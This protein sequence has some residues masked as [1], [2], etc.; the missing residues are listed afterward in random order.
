M[1]FTDTDGSMIDVYQANTAMT[2]ESEQSYPF[3]PNTLFDRALGPL[4]Y[5]GAFTANLHTD[6]DTTFE[7]T[8]T[9]ASA[10]S[11]G[12][13]VIAARQLLTW[14]DGRNASSFSGLAWNTDTLTFSVGVGLGATSLTGMVPTSGP[15]A[16]TLTRDQPRRQPGDLHADDGQ[17][18]GVRHVRGVRGHL[19]GDVRGRR[20][21]FRTTAVGPPARPTTP[22]PWR[23]GRANPHDLAPARHEP[24]ARLRPRHRGRADPCA[25]GHRGR[26]EAEP[27]VLLPGRVEDPSGHPFSVAGASK[28]PAKF[29]TRGP[30]A[31]APRIRGVRAVSL[32][33]GTATVTWST[34]EPSTSSVRFGTSRTRLDTTVS[35]VGDARARRRAHRARPGPGVL[36]ARRIDRPVDQQVLGATCIRLRT[37]GGGVASQ[38]VAEF[39]T[40]RSTG[41][42][43]V[44]SARFGA[45]TLRG[46]GTGTYVSA[47]IDTA[48]K[49][50]WRQ[51]VVHAIVPSGSRA[52]RLCQR[53]KHACPERHLVGMDAHRRPL[54]LPAATCSIASSSPPPP[55][56]SRP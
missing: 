7:D 2:D 38:T 27:A 10:Q 4:G 54:R 22:S 43:Y 3:T 56:P 6:Q 26:P 39:R 31:T 44:S 37:V 55:L 34:D 16:K 21:R 51:A 9:L 28:A 1:R 8:Q 19:P 45:L 32:P 29:T 12:V 49:V 48:Q 52:L 15:G 33:D 23:G 5:Y 53:R 18:P 17:G 14:L 30:D 50:T 24:D 11:R 41:A 47:V 42:L 36:G 40:G 35:M 20:R 46:P 13:P 25:P